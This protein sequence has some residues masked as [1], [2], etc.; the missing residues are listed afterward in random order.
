MKLYLGLKTIPELKGLTPNQR[1]EVWA[2][3]GSSAFKLPSFWLLLL[4]ISFFTGLGSF[5]GG[6]F[7]P[8]EHGYLV[9]PTIFYPVAYWISMSWHIERSRPAL[10]SIAESLYGPSNT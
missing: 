8:W 10:K 7:V 2:R 5:L 4:F 9:G 3:N 1:T 6:V